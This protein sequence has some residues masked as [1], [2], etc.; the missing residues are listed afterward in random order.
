MVS[1]L[2]GLRMNT[3]TKKYSCPKIQDLQ[4]IKCYE[5]SDPLIDLEEIFP[6][7]QCVY[8]RKDSEVNKVLVRKT[9]A[10]KLQRVQMRLGAYDPSL[11]L[12]MVEGYRSPSYQE[13][14]FLKQLFTEYKIN[15]SLDLNSILEHV[16][17]FVAI[18]SVA[19]HPTGGAVDLTIIRDSSEIDMGGEIADFSNSE[20]LPTYSSS[21]TPQQAKNRLLLH[22]LMLAEG[23]APYYGEWWHFSY[24]DREWAYFYSLSQT[25]FSPIF[26]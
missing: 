2:K 24:G 20:R 5:N 14:Y 18:P 21:I 7:L 16:N 10:E 19:G 8:R 26:F 23:F 12:L 4:K 13:Y 22:D 17:Q 1:T 3:Q 9:L 15:P 25:L 6:D 11:K